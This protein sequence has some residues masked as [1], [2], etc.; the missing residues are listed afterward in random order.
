MKTGRKILPLL[1]VVLI[2]AVVASAAYFA[3]SG[4]EK[5]AGPAAFN[6]EKNLAAGTVNPPRI[7]PVAFYPASPESSWET[8]II[9][10][11]EKVAP[12]VVY[13]DTVRTV[14][15]GRFMIPE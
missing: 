7:T 12:A 8:A 6:G 3:F 4:G 10:V 9:K 15:G 13:I 5:P 2:T 11:R 14:S 1:L